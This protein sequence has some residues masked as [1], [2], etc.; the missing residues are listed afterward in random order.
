M[1]AKRDPKWKRAGFQ[2]DAEYRSACATTRQTRKATFLRTR[3]KGCTLL[4][5]EK[6][7]L[8]AD[9]HRPVVTLTKQDLVGDTRATLP[10]I[11]KALKFL[12][13]EGSVKPIKNW[14]G[15]KKVPTTWILKVPV[16]SESPADM[17]LEEIEAKRSREAAWRF[18]SGKYGPR[19]ALEI[20]GEDDD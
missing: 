7:W 13:E 6:M 18:L 1:T 15:G 17:N 5:L 19:K 10:T 4:T 12:R 8:R 20:M 16:S 14:K 9:F 2:N 3:A 11:K